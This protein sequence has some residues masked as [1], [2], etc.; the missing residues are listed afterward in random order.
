MKT[1]ILSLAFLSSII[2][3]GSSAQSPSMLSERVRRQDFHNIVAAANYV[4]GD[5]NDIYDRSLIDT[6]KY[7]N[8]IKGQSY[9][10]K[11]YKVGIRDHVRHV[12]FGSE[13]RICYELLQNYD[14]A[15]TNKNEI[16]QI[17]F[18]KSKGYKVTHSVTT[19]VETA[20]GFQEIIEAVFTFADVLQVG[21][22]GTMSF[23]YTFGV[24]KQYSKEEYEEITI[25]KTL[26]KSS[27]HPTQTYFN[28]GQVAV[29]LEALV[30]ESYTKERKIFGFGWSILGNTRRNNY[31]AR[32]YL[33]SIDEIT[34]FND[35]FG[36]SIDG[37][38]KFA[39]YNL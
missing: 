12:K 10:G 19:S 1:K 37:L 22:K 9:D 8:R 27:I 33:S 24:S 26:D 38:Y 23:E 30:E 21:T 20:I 4:T 11:G 2:M 6:N 31:Y 28:Y 18:I 17:K 34:Y 36:N 15:Y 25:E 13:L 29:Y 3:T 32:Y 16:E 39:T 35:Y 7:V 14:S 5:L